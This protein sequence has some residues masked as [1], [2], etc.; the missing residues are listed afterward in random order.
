MS[1]IE[2]EMKENGPKLFFSGTITF[3]LENLV[4][5][6]LGPTEMTI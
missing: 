3:T 5:D 1:A 2:G 6:Y 4:L